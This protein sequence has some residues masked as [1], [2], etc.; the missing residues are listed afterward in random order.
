MFSYIC[1]KRF[2]S[3]EQLNLI[4]HVGTYIDSI[5]PASSIDNW[6]IV[7][8][9]ILLLNNKL[10][11]NDKVIQENNILNILQKILQYVVCVCVC[12]CV[13]I[14]II[15]ILNYSSYLLHYSFALLYTILFYWILRTNYLTCKFI[16][17]I[18][19][20]RTITKYE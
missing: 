11:Y 1:S 13:C 16:N 5:F 20:H 3:W 15:Y 4:S 6:R 9:F 17:F 14:I 19:F 7:K 18:L 8:N 10:K 12:V 2:T